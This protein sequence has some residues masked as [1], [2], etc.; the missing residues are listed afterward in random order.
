MDRK[1]KHPECVSWR[2]FLLQF[3]THSLVSVTSVGSTQTNSS[4][5]FGVEIH[6]EKKSPNF[7]SEAETYRLLNIMKN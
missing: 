1:T 6:V 7:W 5:D 2:V 3:V 4:S